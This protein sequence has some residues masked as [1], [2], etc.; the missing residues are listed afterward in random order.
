M[1]NIYLNIYK[2]NLINLKEA[3]RNIENNNVVAIPSVTA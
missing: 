3:K 2:P 1:K